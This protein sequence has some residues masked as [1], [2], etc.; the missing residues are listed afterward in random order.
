MPSYGHIVSAAAARRTTAS[1][2]DIVQLYELLLVLCWLSTIMNG[3]LHPSELLRLLRLCYTVGVPLQDIVER[4]ELLLVLCFVFAQ[5]YKRTTDIPWK[6]MLRCQALPHCCCCCCWPLH[7]Y[8]LQDIVERFE[9]LLVLCFVVVDATQ[10]KKYWSVKQL[11]M[12]WMSVCLPLQDIVERFELLLVLCCALCLHSATIE[13][14]TYFKPPAAEMP[15]VFTL[16]L[17][18]LRTASLCPCR[19]LLSALSCCWCCALWSTN[20]QKQNTTFIAS[21]DS[22]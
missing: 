20:H 11:L 16:S 12:P 10:R 15:R 6:Q 21:G 5:Q 3:I 2:Q 7:R 14:Q 17:L 8:V 9:L 22:I 19:T 4:F 13:H 1:L 18:L